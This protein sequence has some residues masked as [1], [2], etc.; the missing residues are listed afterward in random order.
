MSVHRPLPHDSALRHAN[1]SARY[2]DDL[3]EAAD[4]L[5]LALVLSPFAHARLTGIDSTAA[6]ALPGV[7]GVYTAAAIPGH[8]DVAATA[9]VEPALAVDLVEYYGQPVAVVAATSYDLARRAAALVKVMGEPLPA[10]VTLQQALAANSQHVPPV[11]MQRGEPEAALAA[12]PHRLSGELEVGGQEHFYLEGQIAL[13]IPQEGGALLVHSSSQHP[14]EVQQVVAHMVG[15]PFNAVTVEVRRMGG[16]FGG[17]ESQAALLA[18]LAGLVAHHTG[19]PA[20]LRYDRD[21]DMIVTGKRHEFLLRWQVGCDAEGRITAVTMDLAARCGWSLDLSPAVISRALSHADNAYFYPHVRLR[22]IALKTNSQSNTAFRGFGAPQ[23]MLAAEAMLDH[24][25]HALKIDPLL[26][27]QRNFYGLGVR[28][29]TPYHQTVEHFKIPVM[30]ESLL[31][32]SDYH[33]RRAA[34]AAFN[35]SHTVLKKGLAVMPLKF[36]VSFNRVKMNQAG[37]LVHIYTDGSVSLNHGGTEMGQGLFVKVGQVV[38]EVFGIELNHVRLTATSTDKVPNTSPTAASSGSD[39]NG[40]AA[41]IAAETLKARLAEVAAAHFAVAPDSLIFADGLVKAGNRTMTFAE[42]AA[43]AH[44][45]RVS[46]SATGFY[47]TPKLH[48]DAQAMRGRPFYYFVH[49]VAISEVALDTLTGEWKALRTD[50]LHD[51]GTSLN[52][53]IDIGQIE[54]AFVQGVGWLTLEE[55]LW[56]ADGRLLTHAP[57]T[58]KIPTARDVPLDLRVSLLE[59]AANEEDSIYRSKAIG[60]PPLMLGIATWLA[61]RDAVAACGSANHRPTLAAPATPERL[62]RAVMAA[63][64]ESGLAEPPC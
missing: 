38:A 16:G 34:I 25:A 14:T 12:A 23:G 42:I 18:G 39:L 27:R 37:A 52:P 21:V 58:Y 13:A 6:R 40:M 10:L 48:W 29:L 9:P 63:R 5:H 55:L 22:G 62:L 35:A 57:S 1:G 3:P 41:K 53:A 46:L 26:V 61:L 45:N 36:G 32:S 50:I 33:N 15:L 54:G 60:E 31:K 43:L 56:S 30:V 49:S 4:L 59:D 28:N 17:K 19:R 20:K 2:I 64:G 11:E 8:N 44:D 7:V 47:R 51:A 24:I